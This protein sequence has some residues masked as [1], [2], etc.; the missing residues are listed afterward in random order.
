MLDLLSKRFWG[1]EKQGSY[2][3]GMGVIGTMNN[4]ILVA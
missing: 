4:G 1:R 2:G 3:S